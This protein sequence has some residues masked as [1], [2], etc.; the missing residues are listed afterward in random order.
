LVNPPPANYEIILVA[1]GVSFGYQMLPSLLKYLDQ[2]IPRYTSYPTAVQFGPEIDARSYAGWL[3]TLP[4]PAPVSVYVH[5]P[6]CAELCL[7]CG[8]H[9]A[10]ARH[11][12]PVEAYV[13]LLL[14]EIALVGR[15]LGGRSATHLHWGGGTP[16]ILASRDFHRVMAALRANFVF[17]SAAELAIEIDPR[18]VNEEYVAELAE[19]GIT[20]A[21]LGV[22]DFNARVQTAVNRVQSF[23]Q[24]A[25][26]ADWLRAAGVGSINLDLM[27]GLPYQSVASVETTVRRALALDAD[28]IVLFGYA[29]VP[30]MK[31]HQRLIP[32]QALPGSDQRFAQSRAA[33]EVLIGAGYEPIG[34]DHFAKSDDLLTQQQRAGHLRRNFQGYT[35]DE[36]GTL[37]GF[38]AS[39]IG[40][41]PGGYVQNDP[42]AVAYRAAI[43]AGQLATA[44]GCA[45][46]EEDRLRR[47]IIERLMCDLKVDLA[48]RCAA[49][50]SDA[51][52]FAA[53]LSKLDALANDGLVERVGCKISIPEPARPFVRTVCAVFDAYIADHDK[54]FSRAS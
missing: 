22:Q 38:G 10:V 9:T 24:T 2:R 7:Y 15:A 44:R 53:E 8:C 45:L 21:S 31:R 43:A 14:R 37:I 3:T 36:S 54:R 34:L 20:R 28:R 26:V 27:Y 42:S 35:T 49:H 18:T 1:R 51:D 33:A 23:E 17:E 41:L 52:R 40:T 48:E 16:T 47:D 6:F 32:E 50:N 5:V 46:T 13:E 11:Y 30:W 29:H 4:A 12:A 25:R 19:A 39:A